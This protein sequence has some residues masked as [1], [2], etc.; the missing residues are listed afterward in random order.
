MID[1]ATASDARVIAKS[2]TVPVAGPVAG[3]RCN[4]IYVGGTGHITAKFRAGEAT[5][6]FSAIPVGTILPIGPEFI[7]D[8]TTATLMVALYSVDRI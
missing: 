7:M 5:V 8:A 1:I 6:L 4:A 3:L 2:D